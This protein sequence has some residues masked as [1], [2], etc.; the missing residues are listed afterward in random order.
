MRLRLLVA[1]LTLTACSTE[2]PLIPAPSFRDT[3]V[4]IA[5]KA[6]FDPARFAGRWY[7]IASYP[8]PFQS[9]CTDTQ[10]VYTPTGDAL[11]VRNTCIRDGKLSAIEGSAQVTGPGRLTVRLNGVPL[12]APYWVLWVDEGY[13]TAVVGVPSGRAGWILNRDP[14]I[15]ADR[16]AAA[17][18]VLAFNG[19]DLSRLQA[20]PQSNR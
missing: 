15:L 10:A 2:S 12:A 13:R 18:E 5:S 6:V 3:D 20:T 1:A 9:G 14:S 4:P 8:T 7:E 11:A 17:R 16:L 19:Y